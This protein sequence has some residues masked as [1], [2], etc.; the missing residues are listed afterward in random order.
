MG[1]KGLG[2]TEADCHQ[3][4]ATSF[5]KPSSLCVS[6]KPRKPVAGTVFCWGLGIW[7]PERIMENV[8]AWGESSAKYCMDESL[9]FWNPK[10]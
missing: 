3:Y 6:C 2:G 4:S 5:E 10:L 9:S 7:K 8:G 1:L